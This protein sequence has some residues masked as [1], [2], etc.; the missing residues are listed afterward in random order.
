M[1]ALSIDNLASPETIAVQQFHGYFPRVI[2][3]VSKALIHHW[4]HHGLNLGIIAK[5]RARPPSGPARARALDR[6]TGESAR[7]LE[8]DN[9]EWT[10]RA[11]QLR[12]NGGCWAVD[13][14]LKIDVSILRRDTPRNYLPGEARRFH[15]NRSLPGCLSPRSGPTCP[16]FPPSSCLIF[17]RR[18]PPTRNKKKKKKKKKKTGRMRETSA[19][20]DFEQRDRKRRVSSRFDRW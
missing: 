7:V 11:I 17:P 15:G 10:A 16:A 14:G 6:A 8:R 20:F 18:A 1:R 4:L 19:C 9:S 13:V 3:Y 12:N 5:F 2:P